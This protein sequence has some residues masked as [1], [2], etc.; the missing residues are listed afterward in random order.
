[1]AEG[2]ARIDAE[3]GTLNEPAWH[4]RWRAPELSLVLSERAAALAAGR[5]DEPERLRAEAL[6]V[7][8]LNRLDRGV[9]A[10]ER[11][12]AALKAAESA[13]DDELCWRLRIELAASARA[14]GVPL[15]GF[16]VLKPVLQTGGAAAEIRA[17]ALVGLS[18]CLVVIG[19]SKELTEAL[20]EADR[21]Y[22]EDAQLDTDTKLLSRALLRASAARQHRRWGDL[23]AAVES[24]RDGLGLL[25]QLT[26]SAADSGYVVGRLVLE[27][28]CGLMDSE[29]VA[30]AIDAAAPVVDQPVRA[31]SAAAIGWLKLALATRVHLPAGRAEIANDLLCDVADS[32]ERH[33]LDALLSESKL[34]LAHVHELAGRL[35]DALACLR[36]AHAAE[37]RRSRALYSVRAKL[38]EE[39]SAAHREPTG[40]KEQLSSIVRTPVRRGQRPPDRDDLTGL[41][42]RRGFRRQLDAVVNGGYVDHALTLVL[43]DVDPA[44]MSGSGKLDE[45]VLRQVADKV[46]NTAPDKAAVGRVSGDELAVLLPHTTRD[47]AQRWA[48]EFRSEVTPDLPVTVRTAVAEYRQGSGGEALLTDADR[49]L[50]EARTELGVGETPPDVAGS[51]SDVEGAELPRRRARTPEEPAAGLSAAWAQAADRWRG[52]G[53]DSAGQPD[54][55]VAKAEATTGMFSDDTTSGE[56]S[57]PSAQNGLAAFFRTVGE[58]PEQ[59]A[60][61]VDAPAPQHTGGRRR[62]EDR[63]AAAE[64][65]SRHATDDPNRPSL[66]SL[67]ELLA[68]AS[69]TGGRRRAPEPSEPPTSAESEV[70][71][72]NQSSSGRRRKSDTD[73]PEV[74]GDEVQWKL[75]APTASKST[76]PSSSWVTEPDALRVPEAEPAA[77]AVADSWPTTPE[78]SAPEL[79]PQPVTLPPGE[80]PGPA[81]PDWDSSEAATVLFDTSALGAVPPASPTYDLEPEWRPEPEVSAPGVEPA[82]EQREE[83]SSSGRRSRSELA[84]LLAE[85]L[86]AFESTQHEEEKEEQA[87]EEARRQEQLRRAQAEQPRQQVQSDSYDWQPVSTGRRAKREEGP[88]VQNGSAEP[89]MLSDWVFSGHN[90]AASPARPDSSALD[91]WSAP[92]FADDHDSVPKRRREP[93][94][95]WSEWTWTPP[96]R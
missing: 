64:P 96:D 80:S 66:A 38:A 68:A 22:T 3:V 76:V 67:A 85:A 56:R 52:R 40:L 63:V 73:S 31:P 75:Q 1:M 89:P 28:V 78:P 59:P 57:R 16:G 74:A 21:L 65:S 71:T 51:P 26:D 15:T 24:A 45:Q 81:L 44:A 25:S 33:Q 35:S 7:F 9:Q 69:G 50:S 43:L 94:R 20:D 92:T 54:Q 14:A 47:Q 37:R 72:R 83:P 23:K 55:I 13:G 87:R 32:A 90:G 41:L 86:V 12:V 46:K 84:D 91:S 34:A 18:D 6:A 49:A 70:P 11:A 19:R 8:A 5:R 48:D 39:F 4:L 27:L 58:Q 93:E 10:A 77:Q 79:S 95:D 17:A 30:E 60:P 36:S 42:N 61:A 53:T 88:G 2:E 29:Q 82:T 62:A